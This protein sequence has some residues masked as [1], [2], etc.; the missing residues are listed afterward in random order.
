MENKEIDV[1]KFYDNMKKADAETLVFLAKYAKETQTLQKTQV[2][3]ST[4]IAT[5]AGAAVVANYIFPELGKLYVGIGSVVFGSI[6]VL[7][8]YFQHKKEK[9][10]LISRIL[11]SASA[12]SDNDLQEAENYRQ[13]VLNIIE[14]ERSQ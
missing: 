6:T 10:Q 4:V 12:P 3:I 2:L 14:K 8:S 5:I 1:E 11:K 13:E 7:V 9:S